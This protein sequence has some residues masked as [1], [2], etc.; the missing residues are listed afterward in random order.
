MCG[1]SGSI[2]KETSFNLYQNNLQRGYYSS[3]SLVLNG[4][5]QYG[6]AKIPGQ[7]NTSQDCIGLSGCKFEAL[8]YLYHSRGPTTETNGFIEENNHPFFYNDWIVAH[9]GIISNFEYLWKEYEIGDITGKTDSCIIPRI[10]T[11]ELTIEKALEKLKGT[12]ALWMYN[13]SSNELYITRCG[14]T[15]FINKGT[16]DFS[17]TPFKDSEPLDEGVIYRIN[18]KVN[19]NNTYTEP[20][21]KY[22]INSPYFII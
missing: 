21:C 15:L 12:F 7:F 6:C 22:K 8:Y 17:S 10:L 11:K 19:K 14:S 3:G 4:A 20:I 5:G 9:N 16:G 13:K 18:Y 1:I 2:N